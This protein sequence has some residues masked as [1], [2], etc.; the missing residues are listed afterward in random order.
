MVLNKD[1]CVCDSVLGFIRRRPC[2]RFLFTIL[3]GAG[4][5][6]LGEPDFV[7][8]RAIF[9]SAMLARRRGLDVVRLDSVVSHLITPLFPLPDLEVGAAAWAAG[10]AAVSV[11]RATH[12]CAWR[13]GCFLWRLEVHY[14]GFGYAPAVG[15]R[16]PF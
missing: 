5:S 14:C 12:G 6:Q 11:V 16:C 7:A 15:A 1:G 2:R 8:D 4:S 9:D 10:S 3:A 13:L